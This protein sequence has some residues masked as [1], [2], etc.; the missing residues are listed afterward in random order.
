[1]KGTLFSFS[2]VYAS[3]LKR[4]EI[5]QRRCQHSRHSRVL[6]ALR[7]GGY[8]QT[9]DGV[10]NNFAMKKTTNTFFLITIPS[11]LLYRM[12]LQRM[13]I[14]SKDVNIAC[15]ANIV[16]ASGEATVAR[17]GVVSKTGY[18]H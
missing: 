8:D 2:F 12:F 9:N 5:G 6:R 3:A 18:E 13:T 7:P 17:C 10:M 4:H 14:I 15:V 11:F 16:T 1:M